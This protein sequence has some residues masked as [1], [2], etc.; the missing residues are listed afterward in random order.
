M[1]FFLS[2]FERV[3][4]QI[5]NMCLRLSLIC[6]NIPFP[7]LDSCFQGAVALATG[8]VEIGLQL[9]HAMV[10]EVVCSRSRCW[11]ECRSTCAQQRK[12]NSKKINMHTS[13]IGMV[14]QN[15][16]KSN[17]EAWLIL[18]ALALNNA[19]RVAGL[20][21]TSLYSPCRSWKIHSPSNTTSTNR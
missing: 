18:Y 5:V 10:I 21:A 19:R 9:C 20:N 17:L 16:A 3:L 6:V 12:C 1:Y 11:S 4:L 15:K 7:T 8:L 13:C 14:A 2:E